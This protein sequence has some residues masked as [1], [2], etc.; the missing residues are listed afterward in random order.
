MMAR[1]FCISLLTKNIDVV[2]H[3]RI[4]DELIKSIIHYGQ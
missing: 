3:K 2:S 4:R 1:I